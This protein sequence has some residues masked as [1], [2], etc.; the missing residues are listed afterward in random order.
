MDNPVPGIVA[1]DSWLSPFSEII[2]ARARKAQMKEKELIAGQETLNDFATGYLFFGLHRASSHWIFREWAPN[3]TAV[4]LVGDFSDWKENTEFQLKKASFGTWEIEIPL[5]RLHHGDLYKLSVHWAGGKGFRIPSYAHRVVQD[6]KSKNFN[7]QVWNPSPLYTW[8]NNTVKANDKP[9]FIYEAHIG[10]GTEQERTGT[11]DEFREHVLPRIEKGGYNAIQLMAIQ[12]HPY[13]GSFGYHVSNFFAVSSRFGTPEDLKRL[14]DEAHGKGIAVIMDLVHSHSIKNE[15]EGLSLFD[16]TPYQYFHDGNRREHIA[17]D[18]LC[19]NYSKNE[20]LHFLLSNCKFWLDEYRFDGFR[21][22]GVTS[23]L[24]YDHGLSRNFTSY[25]MYYDGGQDED[26]IIYFILANK[27][28]H[29]VNPHAVTIAEEMSGMPGLASPVHEGGYGFDYRMAM[30]VPDF[31]I[32]IIKE[33]PDEKWDVSHLY[34]ELTSRRQD[35]KTVSYAESH[36]QAL[37]GDKTIV[38]RLMD[39]EMYFFMNKASQNLMVDRGIALHKMIRLITIATAGGAYL[40]FM[41]NEFGHP[42]WIDFPREGNNWSYHYARRQWHLVDDPDLKYHYLGDFDRDMIHL[43]KEE[44]I[45][46]QDYCNL[47]LD[48]KGDQ[49]L[50][51]SRKN[52]LF[53]FNFNPFKSFKDY[54]IR[55][56]GGKYKTVLNTD[57]PKYAGFGNIDESIIHYTQRMGKVSAP[58][59]LR[60]YLPT[61]TAIVLKHLETKRIY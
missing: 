60:L 55:V 47:Y 25:D 4:F 33:L 59:Y 45:L 26:A 22:D 44:D 5:P 29:Q 10:M 54:G 28:I 30:G 3:A 35:E 23:M 48:N 1:R 13:Y 20:V 27:L 50:V 53:V 7:A 34:Y 2:Q 57:N 15:L 8:Q 51:F 42:E 19:F 18:S 6:E 39:K 58:D 32:K 36:D 11:F 24:Y 49:V 12:E 52:Y 41:G 40:N 61:R 31:W 9:L 56:E 38:F 17:W 43:F 16:G 46:T 14:I 37:V 21:F